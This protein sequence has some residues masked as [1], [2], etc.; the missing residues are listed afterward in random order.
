MSENLIIKGDNKQELYENLLPQ[1][2]SLLEGDYKDFEAFKEF[3]KAIGVELSLID[4]AKGFF[5]TK[6][7]D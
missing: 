3:A 5:G 4:K 7:N 2:K 1:I 6:N